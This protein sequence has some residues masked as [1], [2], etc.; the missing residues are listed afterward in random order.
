MPSKKKAERENS[1]KALKRLN[2]KGAKKSETF[3][4][5]E[6]FSHFS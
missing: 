3:Y 1:Q 6:K 2:R 4:R 5:P